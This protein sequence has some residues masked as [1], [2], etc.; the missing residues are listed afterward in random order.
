MLKKGIPG[1]KLKHVQFAVEKYE[2]IRTL[3]LPESI[4]TGLSRKILLKYY[5]RIM[6]YS[7]SHIKELDE[8]AKYAMVTIFCHIRSELLAN[9]LGDLF[10]KLVMKI[11]KSSENYVNKTLVKEIKC[12][13]GK[14]DILYKLAETS[15]DYPDGVIKD[16]IYPVVDIETL[17]QLKEDLSQRGKD[18]AR[19][20]FLFLE[21]SVNYTYTIN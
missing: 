3:W 19:N 11:E 13:E 5:E 1:A 10:V 8:C 14:F 2:S 6:A 18:R 12:V 7:P 21:K 16:T 20:N 9:S 17:K 4:T 15:L